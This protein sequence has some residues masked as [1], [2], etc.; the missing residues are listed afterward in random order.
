MAAQTMSR[1]LDLRTVQMT[2]IK[3][4]VGRVVWFYP[5]G[6]AQI[7]AGEQPFAAMI[8]CVQTSQFINIGYL[9]ASGSHMSAQI[10]RLLQEGEEVPEE[11]VCVW[12]PYQRGQAA[13][14]ESLEALVKQA[15]A[16]A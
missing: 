13:K 7:D 15:A 1:A 12:M 9:D 10:V 14:T 2:N 16:V 5:Y 3:P 11:P 8:A 6:K 4:T